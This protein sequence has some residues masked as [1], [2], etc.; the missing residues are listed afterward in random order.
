MGYTHYWTLTR[1]MTE[2]EIG[3]IAEDVRAI[4]AASGVPVAGPLG[5]GEPEYGPDEIALNGADPDDYETFGLSRHKG[6]AFCKTRGDL[7]YDVVV[8]AALL[9]AKDRLGDAIRL[10]S[11]GE[12]ADWHDGRMLVAKALG[13][14]VPPVTFDEAE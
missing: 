11:D 3:T 9:A 7:P 4:V 1:D 14:I 2:D 6:W 13:R 5:T 8:T 10:S 12:P